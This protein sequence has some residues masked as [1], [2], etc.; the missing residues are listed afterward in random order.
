MVD[1][2]AVLIASQWWQSQDIAHVY[3][4]EI[5]AQMLQLGIPRER[6]HTLGTSN[7]IWKQTRRQKKKTAG[8]CKD[9]VIVFIN[10]FLYKI[11]IYS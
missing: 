11:N 6:L 3:T 9:Y 8:L 7:S 5:A 1:D 4:T 10:S 2:N